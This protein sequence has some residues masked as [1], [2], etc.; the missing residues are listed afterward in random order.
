MK[1]YSLYENINMPVYDIQIRLSYV[2]SQFYGPVFPAHWHEHI[3]F[4]YVVK[5]EASMHCNSKPFAVRPGDLIVVNSNELHYGENMSQDLAYYAIIVNPSLLHS[6]STDTCE[7]KY[8]APITRN[9]ILFNN[10]I[11]CDSELMECIDSII[12]EYNKKRTGFE[13]AVKSSIYRLL[14]ILLRNHVQKVLTQNEY[15]M[16]IRN[17]TRFNNVFEY[18]KQNYSEEIKPSYLAGMVNISLY[19]FCRLFREIT[20]RTPIE[21]IHHVRINKS[22]SLL[23]DTDLNISEIASSVGFNDIN[24][25]SRIFKKFKKVSPTRFRKGAG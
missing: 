22:E 11:S 19:H 18:I 23:K 12:L 17:L 24:Y 21:Y 16:R 10:K 4:L 7:A 8:I 15:D 6:S 1:D 3:E 2:T 20:G 9:L 14:V 13:L 5:G 25:F